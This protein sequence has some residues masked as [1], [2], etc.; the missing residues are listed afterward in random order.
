MMGNGSY[1]SR[2]HQM[3]PD[4]GGVENSGSLY[5]T[6]YENDELLNNSYADGIYQYGNDYYASDD[7]EDD[8]DDD[9]EYT[10]KEDNILKWTIDALLGTRFQKD[11]K[12]KV[13]TTKK[14][15]QVKTKNKAGTNWPFMGSDKNDEKISA[16]SKSLFQD[17]D[18]NLYRNMN[19]KC[20]VDDEITNTFN[21]RNNYNTDTLDFK[22]LRSTNKFRAAPARAKFDLNAKSGLRSSADLLKSNLDNEKLNQHKGTNAN[23]IPGGFNSE[24]DTPKKSVNPSRQFTDDTSPRRIHEVENKLPKSSFLKEPEKSQDTIM[25][26][27]DTNN[28]KLS[29]ILETREAQ[30][31]HQRVQEQSYKNKYTK[32]KKSYKNLLTNYMDLSEVAIQEI[33]KLKMENDMLRQQLD[34]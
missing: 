6:S 3:Y 8:D 18:D 34:R 17:D 9:D 28:A 16:F 25:A 29:R 10:G 1:M 2:N 21:L 11:K 24:G 12:D 14:K 5:N 31:Q 19:S 23:T 22:P 26:E 7:D 20:R 30:E 27:L 33:Q 13:D 4:D 32:L 15:S